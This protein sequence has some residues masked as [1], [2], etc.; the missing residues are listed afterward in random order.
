MK[1][2]CFFGF[3]QY[4]KAALQ[5]VSDLSRPWKG[6]SINKYMLGRAN[7]FKPEEYKT[8][9]LMKNRSLTWWMGVNH[10]QTLV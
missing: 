8:I 2:F 10:L 4:I 7:L 1:F 6:L 3:L 9:W 5:M